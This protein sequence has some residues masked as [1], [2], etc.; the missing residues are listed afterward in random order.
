M[1]FLVRR[2]VTPAE[3]LAPPRSVTPAV[4][5]A[6][7]PLD[8]ATAERTGELPAARQVAPAPPVVEEASTD[9]DDEGEPPFDAHAVY[10]RVVAGAEREPLEGAR[11]SVFAESPDEV[12]P[13]GQI[14]TDA[15]GRYHVGQRREVER[16]RVLV[17]APGHSAERF[18]QLTGTFREVAL[19]RS[20]SLSGAV[21]DARDRRPL[22]DVEVWVESARGDGWR[23][24]ELDRAR[25]DADGAFQL[26][27]LRANADGRVHVQPDGWVRAERKVRLGSEDVTGWEVLIEPPR[28]L[29]LELVDAAD[30]T[31]LA[32]V[33]G[34]L[35]RGPLVGW[36]RGGLFFTT[37]PNGQA[38]FP[39]PPD[40]LQGQV[41]VLVIVEGY[42]P[43]FVDVETGSIDVPQVVPLE[44]PVRITG[45]VRDEAGR[46][47]AGAKVAI[48]TLAAYY[49]DSV[50]E[51][52]MIGGPR[53]PCRADTDAQGRFVLSTVEPRGRFDV[54]IVGASA[55]GWASGESRVELPVARESAT[56]TIVLSRSAVLW[57]TVQDAEGPFRGTVRGENGD[58]SGSSSTNDRGV[59]VLRDVLPGDVQLTLRRHQAEGTYIVPPV[60]HRETVQV[61]AGETLAHEIRIVTDAESWI[62]G[63]VLSHVGDPLP[64]ALVDLCRPH[65]SEDGVRGFTRVGVTANAA[66]DGSFELPIERARPSYVVTAQHEGVLV[67]EE[68]VGVGARVDLIFPPLGAVRLVPRRHDNGA[69]PLRLSTVRR[70]PAGLPRTEPYAG[71]QRGV[72]SEADGSFHATLPEGT[73]DLELDVSGFAPIAIDGVTVR[74]GEVTERAFEVETGITLLVRLSFE[75]E[76]PPTDFRVIIDDVERTGWGGYPMWRRRG[77]FSNEREFSFEHLLPGRHSVRWYGEGWRLEEEWIDVPDVEEHQVV[78]H[79]RAIE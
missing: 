1:L 20:V 59:F 68:S 61:E 66:A 39:Y 38:S 31:S 73:W 32:S 6:A 53:T 75:P 54:A 67:A 24:V 51:F 14:E 74:G 29:T 7:H 5:V 41:R 36:G 71:E 57:G 78:L 72:A 16:L 8:R 76:P 40:A 22:E 28:P 33:D 50:T 10:G 69:L 46:G 64:G 63:R 25:T 43:A 52:G 4:E 55:E 62:R 37:D 3:A 13:L 56:A 77:T 15:S 9:V 11:V 17:E 23:P 18:R 27:G 58:W 26:R 49:Q 35:E 30:A 21:L 79:C 34:R 19:A 2:D 48:E 47:I 70:W 44:R 12:E 65:T 60:C 42:L 45:I